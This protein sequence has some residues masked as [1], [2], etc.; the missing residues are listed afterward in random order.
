M[1]KYVCLRL[2]VTIYL[3]MSSYISGPFFTS[4]DR[5]CVIGYHIVVDVVVVQLSYSLLFI[6]H[7]QNAFQNMLLSHMNLWPLINLFAF[8][9]CIAFETHRKHRKDHTILFIYSS[10]FFFTLFRVGSDHCF[11]C[12][13]HVWHFSLSF[14]FDVWTFLLGVSVHLS[15]VINA[16]YSQA[17]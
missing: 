8:N 9:V 1:P 4:S 16:H 17:Y 10:V 5:V 14:L 6:W 3:S 12:I 2:S 11:F 7:C 13:F 15:I